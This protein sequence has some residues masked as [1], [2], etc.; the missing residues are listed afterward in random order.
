MR[1]ALVQAMFQE[2]WR[3]G[4]PIALMQ[5]EVEDGEPHITLACVGYIL[6]ADCSYLKLRSKDKTHTWMISL[7]QVGKREI[8]SSSKKEWIVHV[9]E[10]TL[11]IGQT[12]DFARK[13]LFVSRDL[14][15]TNAPRSANVH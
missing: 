4:Y 15:Y 14:E 10:T 6:S 5:Q 2:G 13:V 11:F 7:D 9:G 12:S 8:I 1:S 3:L